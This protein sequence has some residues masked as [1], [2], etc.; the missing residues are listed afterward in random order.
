M[1]IPHFAVLKLGLLTI[2][3]IVVFK[4]LWQNLGLIGCT[5]KGND[6]DAD[7]ADSAGWDARTTLA[8]ARLKFSRLIPVV[9]VVNVTTTLESRIGACVLGFPILSHTSFYNT[10]SHVNSLRAKFHKD[11]IFIH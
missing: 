11:F 8:S 1:T 5:P 3:V 10:S 4:S 7:A 2:E 6:W 9:R